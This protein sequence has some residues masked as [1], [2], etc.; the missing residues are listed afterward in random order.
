MSRIS[1]PWPPP[2]AS[3][4]FRLASNNA[5]F[6]SPLTGQV[7]TSTRPGGHWEFDTQWE[8]L[9]DTR[10]G[11]WMALLAQAQEEQATFYWNNYPKCRPLNYLNGTGWG[12]PLVNGATQTGRTL[13]CD[14]FTAGTALLRGDCFAFD[15][16]LYREMHMLTADVTANGSGQATLTFT[17]AI[18][19]SP[20]DNAAILLD[21]N[22]SDETVR[23]ACEVIAATNN[24]AQWE[25]QGFQMNANPKLVE[26]PR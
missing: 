5:F 6:H 1:T 15:N 2:I 11:Q 10:L 24:E 14:G 4:K 8:V 21:G 9:E 18:R 20:A 16:S 12:T 23:M 7:Q 3:Q 13:V 22:A 26:I 25:S 19:R 17:P